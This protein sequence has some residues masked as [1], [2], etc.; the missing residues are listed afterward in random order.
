ME[1]P[2]V[3]GEPDKVTWYRLG[4]DVCCDTHGDGGTGCVG[5]RRGLWGHDVELTSEMGGDG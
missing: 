2:L 4:C 1:L 5:R 3:V